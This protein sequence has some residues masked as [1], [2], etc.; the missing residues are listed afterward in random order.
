MILKSLFAATLSAAVTIGSFGPAQA[1]PFNPVP[2]VA[3]DAAFT[4]VHY[5]GRRHYHPHR[6][7]RAPR[8]YRTE[9]RLRR[10]RNRALVGGVIGGLALGAIVAGSRR[11]YAQPRY[12]APAP[13]YRAPRRSFSAA[14]H[15]WCSA[16]YRSYRASDG[17]FQPYH[18][19]RR[20]CR[21]PY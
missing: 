17:T 20:L 7:Y 13:V 6:G 9:R 18:G 16:R 21:S 2:A 3:G 14:H 10:Q 8:G 12:Y 1:A 19:P 11:S 15:G 5:R 4:P